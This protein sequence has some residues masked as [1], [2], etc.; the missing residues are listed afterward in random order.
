M[1]VN[2]VKKFS[3]FPVPI[4]FMKTLKVERNLIH[5]HIVEKLSLVPM[6][7]TV[8][9]EFIPERIPSYV[10]NVGKPSNVWVIL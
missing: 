9:K 5:V 1:N 7:I 8:V 3:L 4:I 2:I 6:T 10:R